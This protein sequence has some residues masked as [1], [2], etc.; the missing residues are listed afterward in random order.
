VVHPTALQ[1]R[2]LDVEHITHRVFDSMFDSTERLAERG[3]FRRSA[4]ERLR[5]RAIE[6]AVSRF[7]LGDRTS[8]AGREKG[9]TTSE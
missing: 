5:N 7:I 1:Q 8:I 4:K 9:S 3:S 6:R 2:A